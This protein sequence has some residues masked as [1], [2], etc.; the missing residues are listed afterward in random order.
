MRDIAFKTQA[1][2]RYS[3]VEKA[4]ENAILEPYLQRVSTRKIQNV[5]STLGAIV[6]SPSYISSIAKER[7]LNRPSAEVRIKLNI[8]SLLL[9]NY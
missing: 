8:F 2:E 5:I 1:F 4:L 3:R 7:D 6:I 9:H